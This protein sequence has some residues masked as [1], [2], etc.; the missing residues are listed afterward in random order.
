MAEHFQALLRNIKRYMAY[1][2]WNPDSNH[3]FLFGSLVASN[4]ATIPSTSMKIK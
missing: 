4:Y 1:K 2:C 3:G